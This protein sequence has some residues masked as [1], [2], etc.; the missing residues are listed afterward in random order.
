MSVNLSASIR[1]CRRFGMF[2]PETDAKF[3]ATAYRGYQAMFFVLVLITSISMTIQLFLT[4]D[5]ETMARTI[6]LWTVCFTGLYK[7][8]YVV[9]FNCKFLEFQKL[10]DRV[11]AQAIVT[12]G[13]KVHGFTGN[14]LRRLRMISDGYMYFAFFVSI[15]L[16]SSTVITSHSRRY[17]NRK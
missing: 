6:D 11:H 9:V 10:L 16:M 17:R 1:Q 7:W 3:V 8:S 15:S 14:Y 4:S 2:P 12:Y 13:P 5:M